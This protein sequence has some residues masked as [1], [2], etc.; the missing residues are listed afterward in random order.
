MR[1]ALAAVVTSTIEHEYA[2]DQTTIR[3]VAGFTDA[4][5]SERVVCSQV[6]AHVG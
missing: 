5:I 6:V 2:A 4:W 3:C 1:L